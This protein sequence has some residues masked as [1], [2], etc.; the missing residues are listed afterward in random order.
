MSTLEKDFLY[1]NGY[2]KGNCKKLAIFCFGAF[3]KQVDVKPKDRMFEIILYKT[4]VDKEGND[5]NFEDN[6]SAE[7]LEH[8]KSFWGNVPG[9]KLMFYKPEEL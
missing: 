3:F 8:F 2:S 1:A 4:I 5:I 9:F 7:Y 6:F